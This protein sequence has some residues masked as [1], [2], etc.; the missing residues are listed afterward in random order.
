MLTRK[1]I[2]LQ[3]YLYSQ[4]PADIVTQMHNCEHCHSMEQCDCY[5]ENEKTDKD[6]ELPFCRNNAP[7]RKIKHQQESLYVKS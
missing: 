1:G 2:D 5:L 3:Y 7:I 6:I 4:N